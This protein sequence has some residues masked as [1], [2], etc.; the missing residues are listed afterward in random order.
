M[1][2]Q[3]LNSGRGFE[4][5]LEG[6]PS[7]RSADPGKDAASQQQ[8]LTAELDQLIL[9]GGPLSYAYKLFKM[10]LHSSPSNRAGRGAATGSRLAHL[11]ESQPPQQQPE[12]L[13][14][15][16]IAARSSEHQI[17]GR[18]FDGELQLHFYNRH[19]AGSA[20]Q[21]L[22]MADEGTTSSSNLFAV[23]SVFIIQTDAAADRDEEPPIGGRAKNNNTSNRKGGALDFM[24]SS[25][26][27]I[28]NEADSVEL[29]LARSQIDGLI[30]DREQYVTYQGSLNR[31]PCSESV[32]WVLTNKPLRIEMDK[33]QSLFAASFK[34]T[35][36]NVRPIKPLH[37]R[38]LRTTIN[39]LSAE[40]RV[41]YSAPAP[42]SDCR[43]S[44]ASSTVSATLSRP[45]DGQ[46]Q[47]AA[48]LKP[49]E[50]W[51]P[52]QLAGD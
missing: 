35:Q 31:P 44:L 32:D 20:N 42:T 29:R 28:P 1:R 48:C 46:H 11:A 47:L 10:E 22:L 21:A 23:V 33:F 7:K 12:A 16:R 36:D 50:K 19:L 34:T 3:L 52:S 38:L 24:L 51:A 5:W 15:D 2:A 4:V 49:A 18:S 17:D 25:L 9:S 39:N 41:G 8:Q 6:G 30:P 26:Q 27:I 40:A 45:E 14:L 43:G 37:G 13:D